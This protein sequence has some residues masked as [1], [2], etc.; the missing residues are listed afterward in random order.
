M[1][2]WEQ[3]TDDDLI[4]ALARRAGDAR[5][6]YP[7][8]AAA[9]VA[10]AEAAMGLTLPPLLRRVFTEIANG[11]FGP[12]G[13]LIGLPGG[14]VDEGWPRPCDELYL[15]L[16]V[17]EFEPTKS[18]PAGLIPLCIWAGGAFTFADCETPEARVLTVGGDDGSFDRFGLAAS[19]LHEWLSRWATDA[20]S[21]MEEVVGH[22]AG[23]N[24]FTK[25]PTRV[26]ILRVR[27]PL[28]DLSHRR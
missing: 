18:L 8:A 28:I 22:R 26:P 24:P 21:D 9:A 20:F 15:E 7:P 27:K 2:T 19:S 25:A 5:R 1:T 23:A 16:R 4:S 13:G 6:R 14:H 11:G 17:S 10:A 3:M 12:G